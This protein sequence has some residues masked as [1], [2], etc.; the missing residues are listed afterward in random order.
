MKNIKFKENELV[1]IDLASGDNKR[2]GFYGID[3][4]K[5]ATTDYEFDLLQ[6]PWPIDD[7]CVDEINCSHFLEH[8]AGLDRPAFMDEVYRIMKVGAKAQFITPYYSSSR[9][10]QDFT[11]QWPPVCEGTYLYFNKGWREANKLTHGLYDVKSDF[12]FTYGYSMDSEVSSRNQ[13]YQQFAIKHYINAAMDL[14]V[15][16]VKK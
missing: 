9:S 16:L 2:E 15:T 3:K 1:K 5:T 10:V 6:Y 11:H 12:D 13:E 14:F 8:I 4:W 7:N